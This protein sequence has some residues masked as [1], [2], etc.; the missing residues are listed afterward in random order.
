MQ[1]KSGLCFKAKPF[2]ETLVGIALGGTCGAEAVSENELNKGS[3]G[4]EKDESVPEELLSAVGEE[5]AELPVGDESLGLEGTEKCKRRESSTI[6]TGDGVGS[7]ETLAK[8]GGD[9]EEIE[10]MDRLSNLIPY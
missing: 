2:V 7:G 9:G 3:A 1:I 5:V 8:D 10:A 6:G 4:L